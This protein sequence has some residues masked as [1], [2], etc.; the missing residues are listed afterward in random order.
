MAAADPLE[1]CVVVR[2]DPRH[3]KREKRY[4]ALGQTSTGRLLFVAFTIR[5]Q[6]I[7]VISV[8]DMNRNE[9]DAYGRY[10][11]EEDS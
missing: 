8:R 10:E 3:S 2:S 5:R 9:K 4:Y 6:L 11:A 7:R 1:S